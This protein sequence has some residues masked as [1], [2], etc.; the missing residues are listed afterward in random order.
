L[1]AAVSLDIGRLHEEDSQQGEGGG[2]TEKAL[3]LMR[4]YAF[5]DFSGIPTAQSAQQNLYINVY[6]F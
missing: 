6:L 4:V 1:G 2:G 3:N 5:A